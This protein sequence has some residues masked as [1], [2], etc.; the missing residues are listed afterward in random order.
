MTIFEAHKEQ[1]KAMKDKSFKERLAY[2]CQYYGIQTV[3]LVVA[4]AV[5]IGFTVNL[6]TKKDYAFT[7]I[8]FGGQT[9]TSAEVFLQEYAQA[10]GIDLK[11]YDLSIQSH[12]N[13]QM[14]QQVTQELYSSMQAFTAMVAARSVDCF[15]GDPDL[16]LYYA[17]LEYA[18]D[19]RTVLTAEELSALAPYLY[20][21]DRQLIL[22]QDAANGGL[23]D[24]FAQRPDPQKP[25]LMGEPVPVAISLQAA[26]QAFQDAYTFP[27]DA[28]I[29]ICAS[30]EQAENALAFIRH[31]FAL[32]K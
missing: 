21:V 6:I 9:H 23:A 18:V 20:Y 13:I 11:E 3:A 19:L 30:S 22:Q 4:L 8:F 31:C 29:C 27:G 16:I 32:S 10:A 5:V 12:L 14:D 25:E 28:A 26:T 2:F 24:A 17:Y 1:W 15:A 7:G